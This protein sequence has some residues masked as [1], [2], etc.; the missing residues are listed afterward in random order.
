MKWQSYNKAALCCIA[1]VGG[2]CI[3]LWE[4]R[5]PGAFPAVPVSHTE[6]FNSSKCC[7]RGKA[8]SML[9]HSK[10]RQSPIVPSMSSAPYGNTRGVAASSL[11]CP[12]P[13][14]PARQ[15]HC[16]DGKTCTTAGTASCMWVSLSVGCL[17]MG[18]E[19]WTVPQSAGCNQSMAPDF[20]SSAGWL[21]GLGWDSHPSH[22]ICYSQQYPLC[23][24][25][26][27]S[28]FIIWDGLRA[29]CTISESAFPLTSGTGI[30]LGI[31][32]GSDLV[33]TDAW[34]QPLADVCIWAPHF[35]NWIEVI[36]AAVSRII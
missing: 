26:L 8:C 20:Q 16:S 25:L 29:C 5:H 24:S 36:T 31:L 2:G 32:L 30:P 13:H 28:A 9:G 17:G 3:C 35:S 7:Q 14:A 22:I 10:D 18:L 33:G 12:G 1:E 23:I 4:E 6:S 27:G 34:P 19:G 15:H 21:P 11:A